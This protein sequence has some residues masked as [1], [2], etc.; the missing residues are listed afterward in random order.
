M[1]QTTNTNGY[2][3]RQMPVIKAP[4][5]PNPTVAKKTRTPEEILALYATNMKLIREWYASQ[6][7]AGPELGYNVIAERVCGLAVTA[8]SNAIDGKVWKP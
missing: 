7:Q 4:V 1:S 8:L 3:N 6:A 5:I 2:G